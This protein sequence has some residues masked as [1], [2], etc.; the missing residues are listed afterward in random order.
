MRESAEEKG[1]RYIL[2]GRLNVFS[3][4][5]GFVVATCLGADGDLYRLGGGPD[6]KRWCTCPAKGRCAHLVALGLVV[7]KPA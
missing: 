4:R 5:E 2:E 6:E 1:R 7:R 3:V